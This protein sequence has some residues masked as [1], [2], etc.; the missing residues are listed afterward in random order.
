ML[1]KELPSLTSDVIFKSF[2]LDDDVKEYKAE[3]INLITGI[4]KIDILN[5]SVYINNELP[6][7][8]KHDKRYRCDII[9]KISNNIINIE[10]NNQYYKGLIEKNNSYTFRILGDRFDTGEDYITTKKVFQINIDN[11]EIYPESKLLYKFKITEESGNYVET[12][13]YESYHLNLEYLK[14]KCYNN[15]K[16]TRLE[17]LCKLFFIK[18]IEEAREIAKEDDIMEKAVN[19]LC[20]LSENELLMGLY[21]AEKVDRKVQNT[22]KL[23]ARLEGLEE[24]KQEGMALGKQEVA[25]KLLNSKIDI[26]IIMSSTGLTKEEILRLK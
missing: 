1:T 19:K 12:D 5:N 17:Y 11:Y 23:S 9:L 26:N 13:N 4:P 14:K 25:K 8:D 22:I 21:D 2:M 3:L 6:I 16:L 7:R 18:D 15:C 20:E 10:M 24:G